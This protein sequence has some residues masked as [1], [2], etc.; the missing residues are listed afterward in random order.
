MSD[1]KEIKDTLCAIAILIA[2]ATVS[3][4]FGQ[5]GEYFEGLQDGISISK[6]DKWDC[7]YAESTGFMMCNRTPKYK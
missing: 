5:R 1:K 6:G 7:A 4:Y 3:F 2:V